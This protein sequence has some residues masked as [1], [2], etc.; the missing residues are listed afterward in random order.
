MAENPYAKYAV[1]SAPD[2]PYAK[3]RSAT[4]AA[5]ANPDTPYTRAQ[6]DASFKSGKPLRNIVEDLKGF[7][8]GVLN[9][10]GNI[11]AMGEQ[12][13]A[14]TLN[15]FNLPGG[16]ATAEDANRF[17][18]ELKATFGP[19]IAQHP[20]GSQVGGIV[21]TLPIGGAIAA[22]FRVAKAT[23][24]IAEAMATGGFRTGMIPAK[25]AI[26]AG[27]AAAPT[28]ATRAADLAL[29]TGAGAATGAV[30]AAATNPDDVATG[31]I[32][33]A[34]IPTAG[35]K[36]AKIVGNGLKDAY[37]LVKGTTGA[38]R[39]AELFRGALGVE[40]SAA[41][42]VLQNAPEGVTAR[43]ALQEAGIDADAFMA[44]G[45]SV[46]KG[47]GAPVF[48]RLA[49]RQNAAREDTLAAAA[50]GATASEARAA[51]EANRF[52]LNAMTRPEQE[53]ALAR[54]NAGQEIP[55][56]EADVASQRALAAQQTAEARRLGPLAERTATDREV[57]GRVSDQYS[58]EALVGSTPPLERPEVAQEVLNQLGAK[59]GLAQ[60]GL[61][62]AAEESLKAGAAART[63][64][65]KIADLRAQG[66]EILDHKPIVNRLNA[67]ATQAGNRA[68]PVRKSVFTSLAKALEKLTAENGGVLDAD[69]LYTV[70]K[71]AVNDK[72]SKLLAATGSV[73]DAAKQRTA[74]LLKEINPL[75]DQ[76]IE[77]AGGKG[78]TDYLKTYASGAREIERQQMAARALEIYRADPTKYVELLKGMKESDLKAVED[79]FGPGSF[80]FVTQMAAGEGAPSRLPAM[81]DVGR[82][83]TRD[84]D[85]TKAAGRGADAA[86]AL[87]SG[88]G[89]L[90]SK[91]VRTLARLGAPKT[92]Y[93][94]D[95][96]N[97]LAEQ[98]VAPQ[99]QTALVKGFE[100]GKSAVELI[101]QLSS[102]DRAAAARAMSNPRF[103][104]AITTGGAAAAV[105]PLNTMASS[106]PDNRNAMAR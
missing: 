90:S 58:D 63:A 61:D 96:I 53:A 69:D 54:A 82:Q 70:R 7:G 13:V 86:K 41:I 20:V 40:L 87:L 97:A 51:A 52:N 29:R 21:A 64:E 15:F 19:T 55:L 23:A 28:I 105:R 65:S 33:G 102:K 10:A 81:Q 27:N 88:E 6:M 12:G 14:N 66:L 24:P 59:A 76:A 1:P 92:A 50:G 5:A 45:E 83:V 60:Q 35:A 101:A 43:Q 42:K 36:A 68:D 67:L 85:I 74:S 34:L 49:D 44:L 79:V 47:G 89:G 48:G 57:A 22:P 2:N 104:S 26:A 103:W 78:W 31:A 72:I 95:L 91:I 11:G 94:G 62:R 80:D 93:T 32:F 100:S 39:A 30:T 99:I 38:A 71:T 3:Y 106:A 16:A 46:E 73:G 75:I 18:Q 4:V 56:L 37:D 84:V 25:A 17:R 77:S 9:T 98:H 8:A